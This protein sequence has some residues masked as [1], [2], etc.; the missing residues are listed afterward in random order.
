MAD[1][2]VWQLVRNNNSFLVKRGGGGPQAGNARRAGAVQFSR[3]PGNL[4]GV[5]SFKYSGLANSKAVNIE[6]SGDG[7]VLKT[8]M[9]KKANLVKKSIEA[10]PLKLHVKRGLRV[11][12]ARSGTNFYRADLLSTAA[13]K[14]AKVRSAVRVQKKIIKGARSKTGRDSR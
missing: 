11:V 7:I 9:V 5:N 10:V 6:A 3:E 1:A 13:K 4:L 2:L 12:K 14:Y 8:K